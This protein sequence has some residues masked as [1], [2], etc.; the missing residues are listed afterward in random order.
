MPINQL[1]IMQEYNQKKIAGLILAI[2]F[3][4]AFDSINHSYIQ[5]ALKIKF[6]KNICE[7]VNLF[8]KYR[9]DP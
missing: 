9:E 4:K 2:D 6:E 3:R 5:T 8:S 1:T 7:W